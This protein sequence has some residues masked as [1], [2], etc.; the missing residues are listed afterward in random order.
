VNVILIV[1]LSV[2]L[3][4]TICFFVAWLV[5]VSMVKDSCIIYGYS[6]FNKFLKNYN[7]HKFKRN[8]NNPQSHFGIG[9][10]YDE[11]EIHASIIKFDS[12]GMILY[13]IDFIK[14]LI[15]QYKNRID[16][17]KYVKHVWS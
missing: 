8:S 4:L 16:K 6:N 1:I 2:L 12:I 15:W 7:L 11:H 17:S 13:P 14:F 9:D 3:V 5:H 10:E